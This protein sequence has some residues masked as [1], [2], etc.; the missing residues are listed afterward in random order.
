MLLLWVM[1]RE[2][3]NKFP[4]FPISHRSFSSTGFDDKLA[5]LLSVFLNPSNDLVRQHG[6]IIWLANPPSGILDGFPSVDP[7]RY[8]LM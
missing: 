2:E 5:S 3:A 6:N 7:V 8:P 4:L 1:A